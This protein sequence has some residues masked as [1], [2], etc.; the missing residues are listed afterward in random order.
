MEERI[1]ELEGRLGGSA[2]PLVASNGAIPAAALKMPTEP[3]VLSAAAA[4]LPAPA[5]QIAAPQELAAPSVSAGREGFSIQ[6]PDG[7]FRLR[8]R[9]QVQVDGRFAVNRNETA[10]PNTFYLRRTQPILEGTLYRHFNYQLLLDFSQGNPRV[11]N[12]Y[13]ITTITPS[14][15]IQIGKF[16]LPLGLERIQSGMTLP[17][18]ERALPSQ[19]IPSRDLGLQFSGD[20]ADSRLSYALGVFNGVPDGSNSDG[21]ADDRMEFDG[22][23]MAKPFV[24]A[25]VAGLAGL[26]FGVAGSYGETEGNA[27]STNLGSYS[28]SGQRE[29][30]QYRR[31]GSNAGTVA[32]DGVHYRLSPQGYY[33][34]GPFGVMAEFVQSAQQVRR[35]TARATMNHRG[36]QV[37]TSYVLTGENGSYDGVNAAKPFDPE[38]GNWGAFEV[39]ARYT[40]LQP[41]EE[42]FPLF[43]DPAKAA[44]EAKAWAVGLNWYLNRNLKL[45]LGYEQTKFEGALPGVT[46]HTEKLF[47]QR[48]QLRF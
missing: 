26:F 16:K 36:W 48:F 8:L 42:A 46:F 29:F 34:A 47:Q 21:N 12:A 24:N 13:V 37:M 5:I 41:D 23:L 32:A 28:S 7:D 6:S 2:A 4:N 31:D 25:S 18:M 9:Y 45:V 38:R 43:A 39:A 33:Y 14:F 22:R 3:A 1:Q 44:G 17:L 40:A 15:N 11:N 30:F 10:D 27:S 20:L 35:G 19:L